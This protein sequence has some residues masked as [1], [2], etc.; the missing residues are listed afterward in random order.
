MRLLGPASEEEM[1]AV[2]LRGELDSSRYG[3]KLRTLLARDRRAEDVLRRPDLGDVEA[4]AYRRRLLEEHR[5]Y[6]RRDGLFGGFPQQV[7]W[8]RAALER[9]EVLDI[10][11]IDWDWWLELSGGTRRPRDAARR[12][13]EAE[14]ADATAAE[15]EPLAAAL[16]TTPPP[17]ELIAVTTPARTPL[18]LVEGHARLTAY[19][20]FPDYLPAKLEILLGVSDEMPRWCQF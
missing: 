12:I 17:P 2:F 6:E 5:A 18:V 19:A 16:Q 9:D 8:F 10:L 14:G 3:K 4:N 7:E 15:H 20:L 1:I 11:Y 13:V